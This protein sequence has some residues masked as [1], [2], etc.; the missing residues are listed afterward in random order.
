VRRPADL[1]A[2]WGGEEFAIILPNTPSQ[3]AMTVAETI[4]QSIA[5][6]QIPHASS[7]VANHVTMSLGVAT[8]IP[9]EDCS[10]TALKEMADEA[11]YLAKDGGRNRAICL[12]AEECDQTNI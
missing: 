6:L 8:L 10:L 2:R 12:G 7:G 1:V 9:R 5:D 11:L 4:R 3:G